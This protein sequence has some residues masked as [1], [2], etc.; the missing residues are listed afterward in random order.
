MRATRNIWLIARTI[1][2]EAL[3]RRE[4]Y[5]IVLVS[6]L[7]L[8]G[9]R[10]VTFFDIEG[11]SKFYREIA[12]KTMNLATALVAILLAARQL[13]R[14]FKNRTLYPLLAKPVTRLEFLLGKYVGV[15]LATGFCYAMFL[16]IF[17]VA[18]VSLKAPVN[19]GLFAQGIYL[20][21]VSISVV[22]A[23]TFLLSLL[24]NIDAAITLATL[25]FM[26]SQVL[27]T[28]M[29]YLWDVVGSVQ[30]ALI[31]GLHYLIPQLTLFDV[32]AKIT[33]NIW[34]PLSMKSMMTLSVYGLVYSFIFLSMAYVLFRKRPI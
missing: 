21:A 29:S 1:L 4:L 17:V 3:R 8:A 31:I 34:A 7:L 19:Y 12:L 13:P 30:R 2:L 32:S 33:H 11:L 9:L 26:S 15:L 28:L 16:A 27:M 23:M 10:F 22:S 6:V 14:E 5:A 25:L 24:L 18:C 20:Q